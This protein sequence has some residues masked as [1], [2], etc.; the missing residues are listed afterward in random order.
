MNERNPNEFEIGT[1]NF[2]SEPLSITPCAHP[3]LHLYSQVVTYQGS[4]LL[5]FSDRA[6]NSVSKWYCRNL[7]REG[8]KWVW[9]WSNNSPTRVNNNCKGF[10]RSFYRL[11]TYILVPPIHIGLVLFLHGV[12]WLIFSVFQSM[13]IYLKNWV[14]SI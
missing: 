10:L 8:N 7:E 3:R 4:K 11:H 2:H 1:S 6:R 9:T 5:N 14:C 13:I 12:E